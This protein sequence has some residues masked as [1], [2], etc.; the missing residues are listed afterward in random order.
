MDGDCHGRQVVER[1]PACDCGYAIN[2]LVARRRPAT[3][4]IIIIVAIWLLCG[5][6]M[7]EGLTQFWKLMH[8]LARGSTSA[9]RASSPSILSISVLTRFTRICVVL[10]IEPNIDI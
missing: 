6:Q 5:H 4:V 2:P 3:V 1:R 7:S 8:N 10:A 9:L